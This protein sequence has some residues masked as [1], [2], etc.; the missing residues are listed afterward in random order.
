MAW[1][2]LFTSDM[3]VLSLLTFLVM[4]GMA[5]YI[6]YFVR[7]HVALETPGKNAVAGSD[8]PRETA[9]AT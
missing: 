7:R 8:Q 4:L 1:K 3:G 2:L 9:Q 5:G 6:G